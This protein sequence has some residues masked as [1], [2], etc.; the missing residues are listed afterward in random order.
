[1]KLIPIVWSYGILILKLLHYE[2][3]FILGNMKPHVNSLLEK[4]GCQ[5]KI[6]IIIQRS[7]SHITGTS[8]CILTH[9]NNPLPHPLGFI[10]HLG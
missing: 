7:V 9:L 8:H 6:L 2:I 1:M 3:K 5:K 10:P 4:L